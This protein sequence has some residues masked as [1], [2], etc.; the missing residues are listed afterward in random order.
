MQR[1]TSSGSGASYGMPRSA[2]RALTAEPRA[3]ARPSDSLLL[4]FPFGIPGSG[5]L[6]RPY[7]SA[8][9]ASRCSRTVGHSA[10]VTL[11]HALSRF[12]PP[13][14]SMRLR[15]TPSRSRREPR[16]RGRSARLGVGLPL[17]AT[18]PPDVECVPKL[19][20]LP[21]TFD[22]AAHTDGCSHVHGS[23]R[24]RAGSECEEAG[25]AD[26]SPSRTVTSG[27]RIRRPMRPAPPDEG[28][29][30]L[31]CLR[32]D[33]AEPAPGPRV[34]R[35]EPERL[36]VSGRSGSRAQCGRRASV[37]STDPPR[38]TLHS[39]GADLR[40]RMHGVQ[41]ALRRARPLERPGG[42]C[43]EC[44]PANVLKQLSSFAVQAQR[45]SPRSAGPSGGGGGCCGG[46]CGCGH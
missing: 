39:I 30:F 44:G 31:P 36:L 8:S 27:S 10:R 20:V 33:D 26:D 2:S 4:Q 22:P 16:V 7:L 3:R 42:D 40:V 43:P 14:T 24:S 25:R 38:P 12:S 34:A 11:Y 21:S 17:D 13:R 19:E 5:S 28:S 15:W 6:L 1:R 37:R 29:R 46:S 45:R 35:G 23:R 32:L 9:R 18:A 41:V